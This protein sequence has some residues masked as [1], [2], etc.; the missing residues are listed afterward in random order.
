MLSVIAFSITR[1]LV[2]VHVGQ[3][4]NE[5][6]HDQTCKFTLAL[7][8]EPPSGLDWLIRILKDYTSPVFFWA[9]IE[10]STAV[11]CASLPTYRPI[12]LYLR[13]QPMNSTKRSYHLHSY[14]R[15]AESDQDGRNRTNHGNEA[16]S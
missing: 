5:Y 6:Y 12:W 3:K 14:S 1:A 8:P 15:D 7:T 10:L 11:L 13:G 4:L 16:S 9:T 2:Y